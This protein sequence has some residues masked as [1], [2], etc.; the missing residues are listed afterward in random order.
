MYSMSTACGRLQGG[1]GCPAHVDA[2]GQGEWGSKIRLFCGRHKWMTPWLKKYNVDD[3]V[4][5]FAC[6]FRCLLV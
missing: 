2:C 4:I 1:V 6:L 3:F 5:S